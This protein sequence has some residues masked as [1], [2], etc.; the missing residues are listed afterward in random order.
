VDGRLAFSKN[1][2]GDGWQNSASSNETLGEVD[3][4]A[5]RGML[6]W[7]ATDS[8]TLLFDLHWYQDKSD[9][10]APQ[11][12]AYV[13]LVPALAG[14]YPAP[15][16]NQQADLDDPR[17]ADWSREFTPKRDNHAIGGSIRADW[18]LEGMV[19]T[20]ISAYEQ[21]K[22]DESNDWDG[23]AVENLDVFMDTKITAWSQETRLASDNASDLSWI[24]G[25]YLSYDE[26]EESWA[27]KGSESTIYYGAFGTVDTRYKQDATTAAIFANTEWSFT[28]Q[29]KL[30]LGA[31]YT[32]EKRKWS[33]CSYDV[34]GG[35]SALYNANFGPVPGVADASALSS[36]PLGTGD[37][38]VVDPSQAS[39]G[40]DPATGLS[41][42]YSGVS[43]V[44]K[45]SFNTD[46]VSGKI[47]LDWFPSSDTLVYSSISTGFKSGGY[48]GAAAST[49]DQLQ[50]YDKEN[51]TA[52]EIGIKST[53][54]DGSMQFNGSAFYYDYE[55][56]QIV[57]FTNDPV[58]GLLTQLVN[59]PKSEIT[60]AEAELD[61]Q[62][63][64]GLY[65]K[66]AATWLA[67]QVTNY[68]GL[69]GTGAVQ[70]FSGVDLAQTPT[71]QY[72]GTAS[73]E[74]PLSDQLLM[75]VAV[76][77]NYKDSFQSAIDENELFYVDDH[78]LVDSRLGVEATDGSWQLMLWGRNLT[79]E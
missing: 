42:Y 64:E 67:S 46:N 77:V 79:D 45:D 23:T 36:T 6:D 52:Y 53:L 71:W 51:L 22:R 66:F 57:G 8:L 29:L 14:L 2:S 25:T 31:R 27:A 62:P 38:V 7:S 24:I 78:L 28:E 47:G 1:Y 41:T 5:L 21:F 37:C 59:V 61:W 32:Y 3:S 18:E 9:N 19:L 4:N 20:S 10:P 68:V 60:G 33:G 11:Y 50:P 73:Y 43:G 30:N 34:D 40:I 39:V 76:D 54:L 58:F 44:F 72:N 56:K 55:D 70:D 12:F 69:D 75:R 16:E 65:L 13:P 48:N 15:P 17:S 74:W 63:V 49:W 35:L 26:V